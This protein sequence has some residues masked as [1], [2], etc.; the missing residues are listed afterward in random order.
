MAFYDTDKSYYFFDKFLPPEWMSWAL[1]SDSLRVF[2]DDINYRGITL[3]TSCPTLICGPGRYK[4]YGEIAG[5]Y[6]WRCDLCPVNH[7]KPTIGDDG[8]IPCRGKFN[9]DNG[10]RIKCV[11][12]FKDV[13]PKPFGEPLFKI[14][15]AISTIGCFATIITLYVFIQKRQTPVVLMSDFKVS[16]IHLAVIIAI[17]VARLMI[18]CGK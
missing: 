18:L 1:V 15:L 16:V 2:A 8:C 13:H 3:Q 9:I 7:Y 12:P 10:D 11:D 17:F 6:R 5:G 14:A 4:V